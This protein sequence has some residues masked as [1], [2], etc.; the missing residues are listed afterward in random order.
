MEKIN[1]KKRIQ[2]RQIVVTEF[3]DGTFELDGTFWQLEVSRTEIDKAFSAWRKGLLKENSY[4]AKV[5]RKENPHF[6]NKLPRILTEQ[7][8]KYEMN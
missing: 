7:K 8:E 1:N 2:Q 3:S 5:L 6:D 4:M